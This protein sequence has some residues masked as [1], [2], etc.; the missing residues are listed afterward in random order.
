MKTFNFLGGPPAAP[1]QT[2]PGVTVPRLKTTELN[3]HHGV[4]FNLS[5]QCLR[6]TDGQEVHWTDLLRC[7]WSLLNGLWFWRSSS[8]RH[9]VCRVRNTSIRTSSRIAGP[10]ERSMQ[11]QEVTREVD[12]LNLVLWQA[13]CVT[14]IIYLFTTWTGL[15]A[16]TDKLVTELR[17][18][19]QTDEDTKWLEVMHEDAFLF[20]ASSFSLQ[21]PHHRLKTQ[22]HV[23]VEHEKISVNS[24]VTFVIAEE[25]FFEFLSFYHFCL[26]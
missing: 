23:H 9:C 1:P 13:A 20:P 26:Q 14:H 11:I 22:T 17:L 6:G 4:Y 19:K 15:L 21:D 7:V 2:P 8:V 3:F 16:S 12:M 5:K 24:T 25:T 18:V 10:E